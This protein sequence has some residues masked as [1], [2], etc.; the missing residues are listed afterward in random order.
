MGK[1]QELKVRNQQKL[2]DCEIIKKMDPKSKESF[3]A[4]FHE[5][6]WPKNTC[7]LNQE[8]LFYHFYI[9]LSGRIKM[10]QVDDVNGKELTLFLLSKNDVFDLYC[11]LDGTKHNVYYECLDDAIVL[12]APME[13]IRKWLKDNPENYEQILPY[14]GKQLRLLEDFVSDIT[15]ADISTRL[16]NLL[17]KNV[18]HKSQNL[19]LIN[20]L[21]NKEIANLIGSTRA[22]VNRHLQKLKQLGSIK[23]SRKKMEIKN[24]KL[25]LNM[26]AEK[27]E[28]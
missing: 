5:E 10:Y 12:A 2:K 7:I 14:A 26:L 11:L 15:F 1:K 13:D 4:L 21:S 25:L 20:D 8:K 28:K 23:V 27:K 19:E 3:L 18:N 16:L 17:I 22:V 9:I 24:L 6:S